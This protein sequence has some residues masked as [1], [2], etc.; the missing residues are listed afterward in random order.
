HRWMFRGNFSY[1][2][3]TES[4]GANAYAD[5]TAALP[6]ITVVSGGPGR[7][8]GGQVAPQSAGSGAFGNDF[9][10]AKWNA[11]LTGAY[12]APWDIN[13]GASLSARQGYPRPFRSSVSGLPGG[14]ITVMLDPMGTK[15]FDNVYELDLRIAKDFRFMNRVGMTLSGD[16]FN[17]PNKRTVLQRE[18]SLVRNAAPQ[19]D[20]TK[21]NYNPTG[22]TSNP[23]GNRITEMQSPR[24]WRLGAKFNF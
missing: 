21:A 2:D 17:A 13:L 19:T 10:N 9:I 16:L 12:I 18:T 22:V 3:Y 1:N 24:I 4:C 20:P 11:N 7:C 8:P 23:G 6:T 5:P 15:R 14:T